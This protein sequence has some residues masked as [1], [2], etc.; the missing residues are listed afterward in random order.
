MRHTGTEAP[1]NRK[2][3]VDQCKQECDPARKAAVTQGEAGRCSQEHDERNNIQ[4]LDPVGGH[5]A[6]TRD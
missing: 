5:Q 3:T 4:F 6:G 2:Y 1:E